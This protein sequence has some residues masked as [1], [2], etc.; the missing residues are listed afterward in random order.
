MSYKGQHTTTTFLEWEKAVYL[1]HKLQK[2]HNQRFALLTALGIYTGLRIGDILSLKW[3]DVMGKQTLMLSEQKTKK[4]RT[5]TFNKELIEIIENSA[6]IMPCVQS[7]CFVFSNSSSKGQK[8]I[9]IQYTNQ[10]LKNIIADANYNIG[11]ISSHFLRKTFGR[12][13]WEKNNKSEESLLKLSEV[14]NHSSIA[15]TKR[16]LG[17]RQQEIADVYLQ[18]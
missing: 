11:N 14:F 2:E 10:Q 18:L 12:R 3:S 1:I 5:V 7:D 6:K 8:A 16:Y 9:S 15:I 4:N 13:V 17:I